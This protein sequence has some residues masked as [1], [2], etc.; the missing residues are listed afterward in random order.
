[1]TSKDQANV[2][3]VVGISGCGKSTLLRDINQRI[4]ISTVSA[5]KLIRDAAFRD[6]DSRS[7]SERARL[8]D[9]ADMQHVLINAMEAYRA[10]VAGPILLDAHVLIDKDNRVDLIE[11][12]VFAGLGVS[13]IVH[14]V[15]PPE[16]LAERRRTD[17]KRD[18]PER[19]VAELETQQNTSR[20]HARRIAETIRVSYTEVSGTEDD[21]AERI[22]PV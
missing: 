8:S 3:A 2:I 15:V 18:R 4:D 16:L 21:I 12:E 9:T 10:S 17:T 13:G 14:L 1:M 6:E 19:S 22:V 7:G 5:S 20:R 11:P